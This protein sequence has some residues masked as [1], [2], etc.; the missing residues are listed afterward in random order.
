MK[1]K[2][3]KIDV[4]IWNDEKFCTLSDQAQ[5][6]FL[7]TLTHPNLT[8]I[9]AMRATIDGL[10]NELWGR[11]GLPKGYAK[12]Y[13][14]LFGKGIVKH[15]ER[16]GFWWFPNF[17]KYNLPENPKVVKSWENAIYYLPECEMRDELIITIQQVM[18][19]KGYAKWLPKGFVERYT[20]GYAKPYRKGIPKGM[21]YQITDNREQITDIKETKGKKSF[22]YMKYAEEFLSVYPNPTNK[23]KTI[24][25]YKKLVKNIETHQ[26]VLLGIKQHKLEHEWAVKHNSFK[27]GWW[28]ADRFIR[29]EIWKETKQEEY[30]RENSKGNNAQRNKPNRSAYQQHMQETRTE[31]RQKANPDNVGKV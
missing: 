21:A 10:A 4:H 31:L 29:E 13:H 2:Y 19:E 27:N 25:V 22:D 30:Y 17:I 14:E 6:L 11:K 24:E 18:E 20:I 9:G 26:E 23:M 12:G 16:V 15:D 7:F 8:S 28:N 3:R 1:R 5:L